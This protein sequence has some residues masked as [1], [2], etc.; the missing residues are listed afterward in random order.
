MELK[1]TAKSER[2]YFFMQ[3]FNNSR[4]AKKDNNVDNMD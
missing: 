4:I 3:N 2:L 1:N